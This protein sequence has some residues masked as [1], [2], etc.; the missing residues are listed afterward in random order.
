M[1]QESIFALQIGPYDW[2]GGEG[3]AEGDV[4]VQLLIYFFLSM[5][6]NSVGD[7]STT[8]PIG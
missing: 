3:W 7:R 8:V 6:L 2:G 4:R 5:N 1:S